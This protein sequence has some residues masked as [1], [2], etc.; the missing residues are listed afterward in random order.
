LPKIKIKP[1][2][3]KADALFSLFIRTRDGQCVSCGRKTGLQ[4]S[5]FWSRKRFSTRYDEENCDTLCMG[6]HKWKWEGEK[7]GEYRD[8]MLKK[9]GVRRYNALR[10]RAEM[11]IENKIEI[12]LE[13]INKYDSIGR[14]K[15]R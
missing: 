6:C 10:T 4:N 9:L 8:Y 5:H 13:A 3:K 7:Q 14:K 12:V 2:I 11:H 1:F 15:K